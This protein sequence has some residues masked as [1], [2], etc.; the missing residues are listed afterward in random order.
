MFWDKLYTLSSSK[1]PQLSIKH[2]NW[3]RQIVNSIDTLLAASNML[4]IYKDKSRKAKNAVKAKH[5]TKKKRRELKIKT[6]CYFEDK[7]AFKLNYFWTQ[8][9][10]MYTYIHL[11]AHLFCFLVLL[12]GRQK[13]TIWTYFADNVPHLWQQAK[14]ACAESC[15]K[16][17][18][19]TKQGKEAVK[20]WQLQ[21]VM[22]CSEVYAECTVSGIYV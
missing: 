21:I 11:Y 19:K 18:A 2:R 9:M 4:L 20:C 8:Y 15:Q 7:A 12:Y 14:Y 16:G 22:L 17:K 10:Y 6:R 3:Y 5:Q 13:A 1:K